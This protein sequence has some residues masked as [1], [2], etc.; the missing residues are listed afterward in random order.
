MFTSSMKNQ[1]EKT[2]CIGIEHKRRFATCIPLFV[3]TEN[4]AASRKKKNK[5]QSLDMFSR[6]N[7]ITLTFDCLHLCAPLF[8]CVLLKKK[9]T[10]KLQLFKKAL[11]V[12]LKIATHASHA[13]M[14]ANK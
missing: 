9:H 13:I 4:E 1:F 3:F 2:F 6:V 14:T 8:C 7:Q 5:R 11:V 10:L 12:R